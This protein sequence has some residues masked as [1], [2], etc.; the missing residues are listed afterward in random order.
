MESDGHWRMAMAI[1]INLS[2]DQFV[3]KTGGNSRTTPM[4]HQPRK[5][6]YVWHV[7]PKALSGDDRGSPQTCV[8]RLPG[9]A[10]AAPRL[11]T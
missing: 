8:S 5:F 1:Q 9:D 6:L 11:A 10:D 2:Y 7:A 3:A 4:P